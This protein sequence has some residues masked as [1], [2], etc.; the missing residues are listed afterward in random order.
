MSRQLYPTLENNLYKA[1]GIV[2]LLLAK[3]KHKA[4]GYTTPRPFPVDQYQRAFEYDI[5]VV[6]NWLSHL[7]RYTGDKATVENKTVLEVGPGADLGAGL[8]LLHKGAKSYSAI[9]V[10][11][12][13]ES[14]PTTFYESFVEHLAR[15]APPVTPEYLL[16]Q[17]GLSKTN[18]AGQLNYVCRPDF[19]IC[20]AFDKSSVDLVF[21]QAAFEHFDDVEQTIKQ[22]SLVS[23]P[24]AILVIEIDLITHSR[25]I[26]DKDPNN[27][28]RYSAE[29][30]KLFDF[31]GIPNRIR[32]YEYR[33]FLEENGWTNISITQQATISD[34]RVRETQPYLD[35]RFQH[36]SCDMGFL[37]IM[38]CATRQP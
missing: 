22:L 12:L 4:R 20:A 10:H 29:F 2:F 38:I 17:V 26:R 9:D 7:Q 31:P 13:A 25:W 15:V 18:G 23:K 19:D 37:D 6:N 1:V 35:E 30:Y 28:Y 11:D 5:N 34:E 16:S 36:S 32:P 24:G 14:V 33:K 3:I 21:S 8:Y 27:I